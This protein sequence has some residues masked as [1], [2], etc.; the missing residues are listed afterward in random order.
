MLSAETVRVFIKMIRASSRILKGKR[1]FSEA[2]NEIKNKG[3]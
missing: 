1:P 2:A 3:G